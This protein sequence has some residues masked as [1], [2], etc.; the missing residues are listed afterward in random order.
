MKEHKPRN[1]IEIADK[2]IDVIQNSDLVKH[3][4]NEIIQQ[5]EKVK[6]SYRYTAPEITYMCWEELSKILSFYF[7]PSNSK[8]ETEIMIIF[9]D[10]SGS[11]ED[12]WNGENNEVC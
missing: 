4:A 6:K 9:N 5:I 12:Y 1:L 10:L 2:I 7:V 8:W 3:R 11:V